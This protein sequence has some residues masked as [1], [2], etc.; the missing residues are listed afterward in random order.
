MQNR[1][2]KT[3]HFQQLPQ[4]YKD[5]KNSRV[6][7]HFQS[8]KIFERGDSCQ[9]VFQVIVEVLFNDAYANQIT[10]IVVDE[11]QLIKPW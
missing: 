4:R 2:R 10:V 11:V 3:N 9:F 8:G 5:S 1:G 7:C 6:V